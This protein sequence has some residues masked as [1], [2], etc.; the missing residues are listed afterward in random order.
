MHALTSH[1]SPR[2]TRIVTFAG[3]ALLGG[4]LLLAGCT[5]YQRPVVPAAVT[6][7]EILQMTKAGDPPDE[8]I[9]KMRNSGTV[10]R[11]DASQLAKLHDEGVSDKVID[12]MQHTYLAAVARSSRLESWDY[13]YMGPGG[14]WYGGVPY[15]WP[16]G[17]YWP[18]PYFYYGDGH[19]HREFHEG[20]EGHEFHEGGE[21]HEGGGERHGGR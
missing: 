18:E 2:D 12:Y 6:V 16:G 21:H 4:L 19:E 10:Y 5:S 11:L 7:P 8:I 17:W 1:E 14:W 3:L 9:R 13:W 20:H 15:G